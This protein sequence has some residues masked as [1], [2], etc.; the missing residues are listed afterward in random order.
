MTQDEFI[1]GL[2]GLEA[3]LQRDVAA[4]FREG[5][6]WPIF[7]KTDPKVWAAVCMKVA[8]KSVSV[9]SLVLADFKKAQASIETGV[10][11][12]GRE[13]A[14][15]RRKKHNAEREKN[16]NDWT[17]SPKEIAE[18]IAKESGNKSHRGIADFLD[19]ASDE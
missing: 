19:G 7:R 13:A 14:E 11:P 1:A 6:L 18:E 9:V 4:E 8:E 10:T 3:A 2:E 5:V 16:L 15:E 17:K 12:D